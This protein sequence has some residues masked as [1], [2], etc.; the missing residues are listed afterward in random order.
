MSLTVLLL[1]PPVAYSAFTFCWQCV[2]RMLH[3]GLFM[4]ARLGD[5]M[6]FACGACFF[7]LSSLS[8]LFGLRWAMGRQSIL[9]Y[10]GSG[11]IAMVGKDCVAICSDTRYGVQQVTI[12]TDLQRV[13]Q[14]HDKLFMGLPG[15]VTDV[16][17]LYVGSLT[18]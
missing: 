3:F 15:L 5:E 14:M 8:L 10:N 1:S 17:T 11:L 6:Y 4:R 16:Q 2:R 7:L 12:S 13:F 9:E 18:C